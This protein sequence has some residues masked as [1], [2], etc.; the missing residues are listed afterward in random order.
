MT[1]E[2]HTVLGARR[3]K[4]PWRDSL[5]PDRALVWKSMCSLALKGRRFENRAEI[6]QAVERATTYWNEHKYP[7]ICGRR[8]RHRTP[9]RLGL[10]TIPAV[11][12]T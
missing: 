9:R 7:F 8:R 1:R 5:Q 4:I 10:A 11:S 2:C 6:A 3:G 12:R